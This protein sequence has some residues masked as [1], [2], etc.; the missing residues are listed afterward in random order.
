MKKLALKSLGK[1]DVSTGTDIP[2]ANAAP[3]QEVQ[4]V[5]IMNP[6]T[7][8]D[9]PLFRARWRGRGEYAKRGRKC[10]CEVARSEPYSS[11]A[12]ATPVSN[13]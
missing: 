4:S 2:S 10:F 3:K 1:F 9:A 13:I 6:T 8:K 12:S 11:T 5:V 7:A